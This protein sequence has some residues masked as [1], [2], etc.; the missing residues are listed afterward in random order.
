MHRIGLPGCVPEIYEL[1]SYGWGAE[2]VSVSAENPGWFWRVRRRL[3]GG[4]RASRVQQP[5]KFLLLRRPKKISRP[6]GRQPLHSVYIPIWNGRVFKTDWNQPRHP[7]Q[8]Y[9]LLVD[10]QT[11]FLVLMRPPR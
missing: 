8:P 5:A 9:P 7:G 1:V 11:Q 10:G 2:D 4:Y 6:Q 3:F